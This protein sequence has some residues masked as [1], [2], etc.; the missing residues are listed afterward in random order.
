MALAPR[1]AAASST[2]TSS[3]P[4]S[5][6]TRTATAASVPKVLDFGVSKILEE[7]ANTSLTI[8]GTVLGSPLYMSPEQAMG[9][10]GIDGRTDVFAFGGIL[11]ESLTRPARVRRAELQRAHRHHRHQAAEEHRRGRAARC[12][13]R[14]GRSCA[15]AW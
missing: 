13:T 15:T 4:T 14:C 11:F 9:A 1:T 10:A 7:E 6:C 12:P 8:V 5:S 2:A 3:P